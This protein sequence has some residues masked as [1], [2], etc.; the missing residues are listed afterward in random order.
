MYSRRKLR[1]MSDTKYIKSIPEWDGKKD[2]FA[3]YTTKLQAIAVFNECGDSFNDA[4]M[5][6]LPTETRM[7]TLKAITSPSDDNKKSIALYNA[8]MRM[9]AMITLGQ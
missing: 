5:A 8:N 3:R 2:S 9:C 6:A 1:K 7:R 4:A